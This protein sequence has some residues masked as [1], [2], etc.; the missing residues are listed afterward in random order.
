MAAFG[1]CRVFMS[2]HPLMQGKSASPI[3]DMKIISKTGS[4]SC[5]FQSLL[6]NW[7]IFEESFSFSLRVF[8]NKKYPPPS[9]LSL[10]RV[11]IPSTKPRKPISL[12]F[13]LFPSP[14]HSQSE[15]PKM[16]WN[17]T[18]FIS[19][20]IPVAISISHFSLK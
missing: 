20:K 17:L 2:N 5:I 7:K 14:T 6:Y 3:A 16:P 9:Q 1:G 11:K 19:V 15:K 18:S 13:C 10:T 12:M 4:Q 8:Q